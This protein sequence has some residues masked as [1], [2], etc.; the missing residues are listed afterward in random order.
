MYRKEYTLKKGK[1]TE[2][3][4]QL[5]NVEQEVTAAQTAPEPEMIEEPTS[6]TD[7]LQ[8]EL[9]EV[10]AQLLRSLAEY[11]NYRKRSTKEKETAFTNGMCYAVE[12]ILPVFDTLAMAEAAPCTDEEFKKGITMTQQKVGVALE[13]LGI[14]EI[15][16]QDEPFDPE[17]HAAVM[18]EPGE[19]SGIVMR[20][21]QPGYMLGDRVLRHSTVSVSE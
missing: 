17:L 11:D 1:Q 6:P 16:A 2:T 10:K 19:K 7:A 18:Q 5:P 4:T 21:L 15:K 9:E 8:K 12:K 14:T 13:G 3:D 20:V